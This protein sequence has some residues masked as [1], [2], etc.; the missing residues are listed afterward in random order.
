VLEQFSLQYLVVSLCVAKE[1]KK[2]AKNIN[3]VF[4]GNCPKEHV[5]RIM[6]KFVFIDAFLEDGNERSLL[7]YLDKRKK[8]IYVEGVCF[9]HKGRLI[10]TEK[11]RKMRMDGHPLPDF[12]LFDLVAYKSNGKLVL[13]YEIGRGCINR[14]FF[15]YYIHKGSINYKSTEKVVREI[16]MLRKKYGTDYF[17]FMDAVINF[18]NNY[19][20][21][22]SRAFIEHLSG[23]RWSGLAIPDLSAALLKRLKDAGCVQLRW[24]VEYGSQRML[25]II[26]KGT[27][28]KSIERTLKCA[29]EAG[30]YNYI[31]LITGVE[32]ETERDISKTKEFIKRISKYIDSAKECAFGEL[33]HFS[34]MRLEELFKNQNNKNVKSLCKEK[35]LSLFKRLKIPSADIIDVMTASPRAA[36]LIAPDDNPLKAFEAEDD[37]RAVF[38]IINAISYLSKNEICKSSYY[39]ISELLAGNRP[40]FLL[41]A[42]RSLA[43]IGDYFIFYVKWWDKNFRNSVILAENIK[44]KRS[45]AKIIFMGPYCSLYYGEIMNAYRFI[46]FIIRMEPEDALS[47]IISGNLPLES[48]P[49]LAHRGR[50]KELCL[51]REASFDLAGWR[52]LVD[53]LPLM[54]FNKRYGLA[55]PAFV[56]YEISRGCKYDCFFCSDCFASRKLRL[57]KLPIVLKELRSLAENTGTGNIYFLDYALNCDRKYL[58]SFL[59]MVLSKKIK[60]SWSCYM[61]PKDTDS[62]L[63]AKMSRAGCRHI[64]WGIESVAYATRKNIAKHIDPDEV[65]RILKDADKCGIHNQVSFIVGFPHQANSD[66]EPDLEFLD[67]NNSY[68][69][70]ANVYTFKPRRETVVYRNPAKYGIRILYNQDNGRRDSV[71]FDEIGGLGWEK[72]RSKQ[73][74]QQ[75]LLSAKAKQLGLV[76][77][78]PR[79]YFLCE[80]TG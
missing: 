18:D 15:C 36:F 78:D 42:A 48:I 64:R 54:E 3:I 61:I 77:M 60:I 76:D 17:H 38:S 73:L 71:P 26:N 12:S 19:L 50:G 8:D 79:R 67:R 33:G 55:K 34:I 68:I 11:K 74:V 5:R 80:I 40:D 72:M 56:D 23:L 22:L 27:D 46:D 51:H 2:R 70:C 47:G 31:T 69:K 16:D 10:F 7:A 44:K 29:H 28:L 63:I 14:C 13:P 45:Q 6:R 20:S 37:G 39:N 24:G 21:R 30:I 53:H 57:K 49:N 32:C 43:K 58:N 52:S 41:K 1:L 35:Y 59:D 75:K 65:S 25:K 66:L 9:R 62:G 4:F